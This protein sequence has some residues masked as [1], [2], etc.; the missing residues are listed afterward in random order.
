[1]RRGEHITT[2]IGDVAFG[3]DGVGRLGEMVL[4]VPFACDGDEAEV[5]VEE[6]KKRY[7]RGHLIRVSAP[8]PFRVAAPCPYYTRCGGCRMQH[9][10]YPH[11]ME[12]KRRQ[13]G[14]TF[15]RIAQLTSLK[16]PPV[17]PSPRPF[18]YRGK[19]EFHLAGGRGAPRRMGLMALASHELVEVNNAPLSPNRSTENTAPCRNHSGRVC[20][21]IWVIVRCSGPTDLAK[22][23]GLAKRNSS[24]WGRSRG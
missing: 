8:S 2:T 3:G 6:V 22:P 23:Q 7:A 5:E 24:R 13:V 15:A 19:A 4:F 1:M 12:L 20:C 18:G 21:A 14:E 9:I 17:I 16:V 10:A 11:Q